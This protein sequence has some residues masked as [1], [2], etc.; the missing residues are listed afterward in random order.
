MCSQS[1]SVIATI[2]TNITTRINSTLAAHSSII[3]LS[4][5]RSPRCCHKESQHNHGYAVTLRRAL[6]GVAAVE[7]GP[8]PVVQGRRQH[9]QSVARTRKRRADGHQKHAGERAQ[10]V[11]VH[12][13]DKR[14]LFQIPVGIP[15]ERSDQPEH[16]RG[17]EMNYC[18]FQARRRPD[19]GPAD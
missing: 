19:P 5:L 8:P 14:H 15:D 6:A 3:I 12:F 17:G 16:C 10:Q 11:H 2:S 7:P 13:V 18:R 1:E 9:A 4:R